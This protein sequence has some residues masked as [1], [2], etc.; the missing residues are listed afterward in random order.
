VGAAL[1]QITPRDIK[2]WFQHRC[3]YALH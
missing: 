2:G 1:E 3:A